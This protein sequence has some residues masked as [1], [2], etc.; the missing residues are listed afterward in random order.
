[1]SAYFRILGKS[2][3]IEALLKN[4]S[5]EPDRVWIK[6]EPRFK[7]DPN[8]QLNEKSCA[9]FIASDADMDN[10]ELQIK[11]AQSFLE[12]NLDT[13]IQIVKFPGIDEA[14]IDFG[15][16]LRDVAIH[17]D[18]LN[19]QFLAIVAQVG[20]GIELSHYPTMEND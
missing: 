14:T 8:S 20:I 16:E 10:F 11:E 9:S 13:I 5:L 19:P 6:G 7:S 2:L 12:R 3:D 1:M 4:V 18:Y 17:C 15:I